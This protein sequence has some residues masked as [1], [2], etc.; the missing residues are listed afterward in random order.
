MLL[1]FV[2]IAVA[3]A[4]SSNEASALD[5]VAEAARL[6]D[7]EE[8]TFPA[9]IAGNQAL[10]EEGPP[11]YSKRKQAQIDSYAADAEEMDASLVESLAALGSAASVIFGLK[12]ALDQD[13]AFWSKNANKAHPDDR[14]LVQ[15]FVAAKAACRDAMAAY[16]A[17][18]Y[19]SE[20]DDDVG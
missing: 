15:Q 7:D 6:L 2:R 20:P 13:V 14:I 3:K 11:K 16:L 10:R 17:E 1:P 8:R 19:V 4:G 12:F 9:R 18:Y 5:A